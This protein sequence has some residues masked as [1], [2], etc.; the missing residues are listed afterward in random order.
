MSGAGAATAECAAA[1]S[2][3]TGARDR[4]GCGMDQDQL[5]P[6]TP[7][8]Q[9]LTLP[10]FLALSGLFVAML[11]ARPEELDPDFWWHL[12]NGKTLLATNALIHVNPYA[13]MAVGRH[14]IMQEWL[15]ESWMAAVAAAGG[16]LGVVIVY[17][18]ITLALFLLI[19][20]RSRELGP[21]HG[22]TL[23]VGILLAGLAAYP[24]LGP[25]SQMDS[26]MLAALVLFLVE[27]QLR[28]GGHPA[29]LLPPVFLI[30][31]NLHAG[32]I[33]GL[34]FLLAIVGVEGASALVGRRSDTERSRIVQLAWATGCSVAVC[35]LNP[36]GPVI[37]AYPFETQFNT[38]Q[39]ALI[40]EWQSPDFHSAV[41]LP[42]LVFILSLAVLLVRYRSI[43]LR[44]GVVL[45]LSLF[46]TLQSV[47][48][49]VFLVAAGAPIWINLAERGRQDLARHWHPRLRLR[50]PPLV[51]L[52]EL[53][54]LLLLLVILTVQVD[55]GGS[56]S[57][58]S[59]TY[60]DSF[61]VCAARWLE[62]APG[63]LRVFN[64]YGDGGFLAYTVPKDKVFIFGD[65]ALMGS[66][67]LERYASIIDLS[68]GWLTDL[69]SSP[70][71]LVVFERGTA[72]PDALQRSPQ[73][74]LVYRDRRVEAFER[75]SLLS[76]LHLPPNPTAANWRERG[77]TA[78]AT[79][80]RR[81]A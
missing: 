72:F 19:W 56:P 33:L 8:R 55:A 43:S 68:P 64:Q 36:N 4:S 20:M 41:L 7:R 70:S 38:A 54:E 23:A 16:R 13:F 57:L 37:V 17:E 26:Y 67:L 27:R 18:L 10:R 45:V 34:I 32:F 73:W 44:D 61:P 48:N 62:S 12:R 30:W 28:R 79:Q 29:W 49:S 47:R 3:Y 53:L 22:V 40:Q 35:L 60:V 9:L 50:Q 46:L 2:T 80:A 1:A 6:A 21:A 65:A 78:C 81:L 42:L 24:I 59:S 71:Q 31:S 39:Q 58:N 76:S 14:W 15:S 52:V 69:D 74:T 5:K 25:R 11:L 51:V 63:N 75:T 66:Q 77:I